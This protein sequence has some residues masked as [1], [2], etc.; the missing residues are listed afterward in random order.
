MDATSVEW[1]LSAL[2]DGP[3]SMEELARDLSA[4]GAGTPGA[5]SRWMSRP[6]VLR[7]VGLALAEAVP[8]TASR[9]IASGDGAMVLG[10]SVSLITGLPFAVVEADA[11]TFGE[12]HHGED[13]SLVAVDAADLTTVRS[14]MERAGMGRVTA[15]SVF[16]S[17]PE[18]LFSTDTEGAVQWTER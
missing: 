14:S 1:N 12:I 6:A 5:I 8:A 3:G 11:V 7:R 15:H 16:G 17:T 4:L 9:V 18:A 10:A 2:P 13:A